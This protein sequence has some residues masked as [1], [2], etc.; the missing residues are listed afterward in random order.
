MQSEEMECD[1]DGNAM[2]G[3]GYIKKGGKVTKMTKSVQLTA[4]DLEKSLE[5]LTEYAESGD[6]ESRKNTLLRKAMEGDDLEKSERDELFGLMGGQGDYTFGS[7][8][9]EEITKSLDENETLQK[10]L[11]VSDYLREQHDGLCKSLTEL[12][13]YQE[14]SDARQHDFNLVLAKAV[15]DTGTMVKAMSARLGVIASQPARAPKS[16]GADPLNK[17]FANQTPAE[18]Q[19]SKSVILDTMTAMNAESF[20]KGGNGISDFGE[21][22][23][24]AVAKYETSN[25]ISK[26]MYDEV[27][28]FRRGT[29]A[30]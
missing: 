15:S 7:S 9:S 10:A 5:K 19:L 29:A 23:G 25:H 3:G 28:R 30:H 1:K 26:P 8:H 6:S 14:Q 16:V 12:A 4:D 24:N 17:S 13:E 11:D 20:E 22:I 21:D 18:D 27:L 2:K